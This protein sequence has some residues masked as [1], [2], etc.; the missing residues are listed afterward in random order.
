MDLRWDKDLKDH[1]I[2]RGIKTKLCEREGYI[3]M[4]N[5]VGA[6]KQILIP[7]ILKEL[8]FIKLCLNYPLQDMIGVDEVINII[9]G[10]KY[11]LFSNNRVL[12]SVIVFRS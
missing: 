8:S 12:K 2:I 4:E 11:V 1:K 7:L 10:I 5:R 3:G 9:I 6:M